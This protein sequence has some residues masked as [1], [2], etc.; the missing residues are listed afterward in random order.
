[1]PTVNWIPLEANPEVCNEYKQALS[2]PSSEFID[3]FSLDEEMLA[4]IPQPVHAMILLFPVTESYETFIKTQP[5][6]PTP[7]SVFFLPQTIGN[8]C[9]S[10]AIL[11]TLINLF[12]DKLKGPLLEFYNEAKQ[13]DVS[14]RGNLLSSS[15][16]ANEIAKI[17]S[18]LAVKGQSD[19]VAADAEVDLHFVALVPV[20]GV[21]YELDGFVFGNL[22]VDLVPL[23]MEAWKMEFCK[24]VCVLRMSLLKGRLITSTLI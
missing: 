17:H 20:D 1:M 5:V 22:G 11:H 19:V 12:K 8:A 21:L 18:K 7:E 3:V 24:R 9:G 4:F 15:S 13:V 2:I 23:L 10:I 6:N 14:E 16:S